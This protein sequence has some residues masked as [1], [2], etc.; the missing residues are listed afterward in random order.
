M[1][2]ASESRARGNAMPVWEAMAVATGWNL[3]L[4]RFRDARAHGAV[5]ASAIEMIR[6]L[7]KDA[8]E[9]ACGVAWLAVGF[10]AVADT[11]DFDGILARVAIDE[12]PGA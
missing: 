3:G 12:T 4:G 9:V 11:D 5:W 2:E 8:L 7:S 10:A 6:P 1:V